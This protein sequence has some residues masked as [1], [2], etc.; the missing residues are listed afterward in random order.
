MKKIF[1]VGF[2]V[3]FLLII[4]NYFNFFKI[5][6]KEKVNELPF[7]L[8]KIKENNESGILSNSGIFN[9]TNKERANNNLTLFILSNKLNEA[10]ESKIDDMVKHQYFDHISPLGM[11]VDDLASSVNY[12][13]I[14][15]GENLAMGDFID[16]KELVI[17][18]MNSPGHRKNILNP[19]YIEIGVSARKVFIMGRET[20]LAVQIFGLPSSA[21]PLINEE[22][23]S[24]INYK[25]KELNFIKNR[26]EFLKKEIEAIIPPV[27]KKIKE[28][29]DLINQHNQIIKELK[30][31]TDKYN[32]QVNLRNQCI[33]DYGF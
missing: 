23:I 20:W 10:A 13:F 30:D 25:E 29:N 31:L 8:I 18:W 16:D 1:L 24:E 32:N 3:F 5:D 9:L 6:E 33:L 28:Y 19:G 11:G 2:F 26:I 27:N 21:C 12:E 14:A 17:G 15:V 22:I 4:L 7:P